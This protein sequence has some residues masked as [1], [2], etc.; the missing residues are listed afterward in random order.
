MG[1]TP[2]RLLDYFSVDELKFLLSTINESQT[3]TRQDLINRI[4]IEWPVHNKK[5]EQLPQFLDKSTLVQICKDYSLDHKGNRNNL[6]KRIKKELSSNKVTLNKIK[7]QPKKNQQQ[8]VLFPKDFHLSKT[9]TIIGILAIVV[10]LAVGIPNLYFAMNPPVQDLIITERIPSESELILFEGKVIDPSSLPEG[11]AGFS[12]VNKTLGFMISNPT[13]DWH[14]TKNLGKEKI[15]Q[16]LEPPESTFL[17]G[18]MTSW[19]DE[20]T[21]FVAVFEGDDPTKQDL[22]RFIELQVKDMPNYF[23]KGNAKWFLSPEGNYAKLEGFFTEPDA[24]ILQTLVKHNDM[25]YLI[26]TTINTP[27]LLPEKIKIESEEIR[28]SFRFLS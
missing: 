24:E 27:A 8:R 6:E 18:V 5:W 7:I 2:R 3:G 9:N 10:A 22:R 23:P 19:E 13:I 15:R 20:I 25:I 28:D 4:L 26:Q 11:E 1:L 17:G 16:G 12:Y 21:V 14:F